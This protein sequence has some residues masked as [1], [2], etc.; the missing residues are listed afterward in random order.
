MDKRPVIEQVKSGFKIAGAI[1]TSFAAVA[2]EENGTEFS[3]E[4]TGRVMFLSMRP[5]VSTP[6]KTPQQ[7]PVPTS[8]EAPNN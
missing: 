8:A 3:E 7:E 1:L 5:E 6:V 2:V 4:V